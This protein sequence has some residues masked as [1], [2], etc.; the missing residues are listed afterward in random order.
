M[1]K[2]YWA[3]AEVFVFPLASGPSRSRPGRRGCQEQLFLLEGGEG[4]GVD[5]VLVV[6]DWEEILGGWG[7]DGREEA[8]LPVRSWV[9]FPAS[10]WPLCR[11]FWTRCEDADDAAV[12]T[13]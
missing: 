4:T 3:K 1:G 9:S 8:E 12:L 13:S 10:I 6:G 11:A 5:P 2:S 7:R